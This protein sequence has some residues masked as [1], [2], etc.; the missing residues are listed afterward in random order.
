MG[1]YKKT[2]GGGK[3]KMIF[4][5]P[6]LDFLLF[7]DLYF[8]YFQICILR[9]EKFFWKRRNLKKINFKMRR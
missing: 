2:V 5:F 8:C 6:V 7:P 4:Q 3:V 1:R 9:F